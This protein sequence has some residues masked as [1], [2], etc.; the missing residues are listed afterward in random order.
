MLLEI[1]KVK[2]SKDI[3]FLA[4]LILMRK[5]KKNCLEWPIKCVG[6]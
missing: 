6:E 4:T 1:S 2:N 3:E 5:G